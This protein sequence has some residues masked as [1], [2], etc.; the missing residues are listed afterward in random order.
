LKKLK[1][2]ETF[3]GIG[4]QHKALT[5]I[6]NNQNFI[7]NYKLYNK[8]FEIVAT[9]EWYINAIISYDIIHNN[10]QNNFKNYNN[11]DKDKMLSFIETFN[12]SK[13]SKDL[14][15]F[16]L[17]KKF[18]YEKIRELYIALKRNKNYGS[19]LNIKTINLPK[20]DLLT[21]SFPCQD[22]SKIGYQKGLKE[23]NNTRSGLL[24]E[25]KRLLIEMKELNKLP[26]FLLME[27]VKTLLSDKHYNDW[28]K[29][30]IFLKNLGYKNTTIFLDARDFGIPQSRE[31]V[32]C[33]SELNGKTNI[34]PTYYNKFNSTLSDFLDI[35][36]DKYKE[37]QKNSIINNTKSRIRM[38]TNKNLTIKNDWTLTLT[39]KQDRHPN[40]GVFEYPNKIENKLQFRYITPRECMLLMG[41]N[42]EDFDKLKSINMKKDEIYKLTGNSIVV[43]ILESIFLEILKRF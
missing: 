10:K 23:E 28:L 1:V 9:S 40:S 5:N 31:R 34:I 30:D 6:F 29:F 4:A 17:I 38:T 3:S 36:N 22:I 41:F 18:K 39:T 14:Y 42:N 21:Y 37:E 7:K 12:L 19:I 11:L 20:I 16:K 13:D 26:K 32:F 35:N 24:W 8:T 25:I 15:D 2:F 33:I 43:Q 27:N